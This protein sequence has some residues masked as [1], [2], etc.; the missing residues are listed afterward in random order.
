MEAQGR[1][2]GSSTQLAYILQSL[3][4]LICKTAVTIPFQRDDAQRKCLSVEHWPESNLHRNEGHE[5]LSMGSLGARTLSGERRQSGQRSGE[6]LL[7]QR[8]GERGSQGPEA[9]GGGARREGQW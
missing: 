6:G 9:P 1:T 4:F 2:P 8:G 7:R 5:R 3:G